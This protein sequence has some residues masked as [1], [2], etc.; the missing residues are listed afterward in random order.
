MHVRTQRARRR[1][2]RGSALVAAVSVATILGTL[3]FVLATTAL[4]AQRESRQ[5][6]AELGAFHAAEAGLARA[7]VQL[8][9]GADGTIG[10]AADPARIGGIDYWVS[11]T[12]SESGL[13]SLVASAR[14]GGRTSR[15]ELVLQEERAAVED[16]AIFAEEQVTLRRFSR[17]D[18]YDSR[19]G[20]YASQVG[21]EH[22]REDGNVGSNDDIEVAPYARVYGYTQH[23]RADDDSITLAPF[24]ILWDG[25]GA[26]LHEV[27]LPPVALP[28][29]TPEDGLPVPQGSR[30]VRASQPE[31]IGPGAFEYTSLLVNRKARLTV[32]GP[33]E[34][35][36]AK[37]LVLHG[38]ST[39]TFDTTN[40]P[41][42]VYAL[43]DFQLERD[44]ILETTAGDPAR[45]TLYL[46]GAH[47]A[48]DDRTPAI[49]FA[50][51]A[52][53]HGTVYAPGLSLRLESGFELFGSVKARWVELGS[54]ARV[55]FD[56]SLA[57]GATDRGR[58][59]RG[60]GYGILAWRR[61]GGAS[62]P[63]E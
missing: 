3:A 41:I 45:L 53:F 51:E 2:Q 36:I 56:E 57:S 63:T 50:A 59:D 62:A 4:R 38:G 40:G 10:S 42:R 30:K 34:L 11:A 20:S 6:W 17:V 49:A 15:Q 61:L 33:C 29:D 8:Q 1:A 46:C 23:G 28:G 35:V 7:R 54:G 24:A 19:H 52:Q 25:F 21:S 44:S 22:A 48:H 27:R 43:G 31:T 58:G 37:S 12:H 47:D 39:W 9:N 16:F 55:H 32:V 14:A 26:A 18:S 13:T 60:H 5:A